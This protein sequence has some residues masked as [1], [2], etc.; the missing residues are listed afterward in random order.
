MPVDLVINNSNYSNTALEIR[1]LNFWP[2]IPYSGISLP[3]DLILLFG[4]KIFNAR[5][6]LLLGCKFRARSKVLPGE[7]QR[8]LVD[9]Y[10]RVFYFS[11]VDFIIDSNARGFI[12]RCNRDADIPGKKRNGFPIFIFRAVSISSSNR[13]YRRRNMDRSNIH[14]SRPNRFLGTRGDFVFT[15][16]S[17]NCQLSN[18]NDGPLEIL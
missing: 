18:V 3:V 13:C 16:L 2:R 4:R 7:S 17:A 6:V 11:K 10:R 15:M 1:Q 5:V 9:L 12:S 8:V 14:R